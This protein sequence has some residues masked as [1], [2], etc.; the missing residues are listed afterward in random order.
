MEKGRRQRERKENKAHY[1]PGSIAELMIPTARPQ[2]DDHIVS[3]EPKSNKK[4]RRGIGWETNI[5]AIL[6]VIIL[7][8]N[9]KYL[10]LT[11]ISSLSTH[12]LKRLFA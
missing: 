7:A 9:S 11:D 4:T 6:S 8:A 2:R 10:F 3:G 5:V 1:T 12:K